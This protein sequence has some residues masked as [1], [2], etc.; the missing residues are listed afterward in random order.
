MTIL[1]QKDFDEFEKDMTALFFTEGWLPE[2]K[3]ADIASLKGCYNGFF[4]V[5]TTA[6]NTIPSPESTRKVALY[7]R[8][9][10]LSGKSHVLLP[11]LEN[12]VEK[13]LRGPKTEY[14]ICP[15]Y[16]LGMAG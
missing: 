10:F 9:Y 5:K 11:L 2:K 15:L 14:D 3:P 1:L 7:F 12:A 8:F 6:D 16:P 13:G 4:A